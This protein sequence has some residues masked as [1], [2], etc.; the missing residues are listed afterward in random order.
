MPVLPVGI[1]CPCYVS[2]KLFVS[3]SLKSPTRG[4][5]N[6]LKY[7][8]YNNNNNIIN[9]KKNNTPQSAFYADQFVFTGNFYFE[10]RLILGLYC[11][12]VKKKFSFK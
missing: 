6:L 2:F 7:Y 8:N 10:K 12:I 11:F 5:D 3:L 1:S 9:N 4:E